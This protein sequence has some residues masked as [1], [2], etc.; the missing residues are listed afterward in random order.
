MSGLIAAMDQAHERAAEIENQVSLVKESLDKNGGSPEA[1]TTAVDTFAGTIEN[2]TK[3]LSRDGGLGRVRYPQ[4]RPLFSRLTRLYGRLNGYTEAPSAAH[5][6]RIDAYSAELRVLLEQL[7]TV[8]AADVPSL[9]GVL[10]DHD[11]PR[12]VSGTRMELP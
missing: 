8:I 6:E 7:N 11:V 1:V 3:K 5:R 12:I 4:Q 9:N 10:R 2:L